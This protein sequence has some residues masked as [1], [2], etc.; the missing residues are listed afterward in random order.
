ML[1]RADVR[2][3]AACPMC[4]AEIAALCRSISRPRGGWEIEAVH[5]ARLLAAREVAREL[6]LGPNPC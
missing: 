2:R 6:R 3:L 1:T 4:R 5:H